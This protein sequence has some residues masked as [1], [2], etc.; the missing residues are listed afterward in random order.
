MALSDRSFMRAKDFYN[1][2]RAIPYTVLS[3]DPALAAE[4]QTMKWRLVP[5]LR[6]VIPGD[7]I[8]WRPRGSAAGGAAFTSHDRSDL[9]HLLKAVKAALLWHERCKDDEWGT[10]SN[11]NVAKDPSIK[12]WIT[13]VKKRLKVVG[14][15]SVNQLFA[16]LS[17]INQKLEENELP[18]FDEKTLKLMN[19]CCQTVV[20]NTGHIVFASSNAEDF[21]NDVYRV[22]VVHSTK[23]GKVVNGE[24]LQGV[25]E[26]FRRFKLKRLSD[27][28]IT[29][30]RN[31]DK[32]KPLTDVSPDVVETE[33]EEVE[34]DDGDEAEDVDE[35]TPIH[36]DCAGAGEV[37]V[38]IARMCF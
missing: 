36:D 22:R 24:V 32:A 4:A 18:P 3:G 23:Y 9:N 11:V 27:G 35:P 13:E 15:T 5:D 21:G 14:I 34:S 12:L 25:Q 26:Y 8:C 31:V 37:D 17:R 30:T 7:I 10:L 29:W 20:Q 2:F 16:N 1:F 6:W 28:T 33:E 19:E 38:I